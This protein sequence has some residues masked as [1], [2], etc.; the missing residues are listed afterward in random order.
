MKRLRQKTNDREEWTRALQGAKVFKG[1][2]KQA[3][4]TLVMQNL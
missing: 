4:R 3:N 1:S 2:K